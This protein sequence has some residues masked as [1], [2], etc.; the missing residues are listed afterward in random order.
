MICP[1]S[2]LT[3]H[4]GS[5]TTYR[6]GLRGRAHVRY[7]VAPGAGGLHSFPHLEKFHLDL[8]ADT[9]DI[10]ENFLSKK[11]FAYRKEVDGPW[12]LSNCRAW[13]RMQPKVDANLCHRLCCV[14]GGC[15]FQTHRQ[16]V[17]SPLA[18][19]RP[20]KQLNRIASRDITNDSY[21]TGL[22]KPSIK[23]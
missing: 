10:Q 17:C 5:L 4:A 15:S 14:Q 22:S 11:I 23:S 16:H 13:G 12:N 19:Q 9:N 18:M 7:Y 1:R 20:Q 6:E 3:R 21:P 8:R 2:L